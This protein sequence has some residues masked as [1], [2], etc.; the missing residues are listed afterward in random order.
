[1]MPHIC[2]YL[3][4]RKINRE[5]FRPV[6]TTIA[7]RLQIRQNGAHSHRIDRRDR[8]LY[9]IIIII[10]RQTTTQVISVVNHVPFHC[11][12]VGSNGKFTLHWANIL[13]IPPRHQSIFDH[14][15]LRHSFSLSP[16]STHPFLEFV[17]VDV[18]AV[19]DLCKTQ[20]LDHHHHKKRK[21]Q[22]DF[23]LLHFVSLSL[24]LSPFSIN[25]FLF[26]DCLPVIR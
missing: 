7:T 17:A 10:I 2:R 12:S 1:M 11:L 15:D 19:V 14:N 26:I 21:T 18:G 5:Y 13:T 9:S 24:S 22:F 4:E 8:T 16:P 20:C 6:T 25:S 3:E 23:F